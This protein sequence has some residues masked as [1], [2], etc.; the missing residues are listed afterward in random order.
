MVLQI[1]KICADKLPCYASNALTKRQRCTNSDVS[2]STAKVHDS[3]SSLSKP[4]EFLNEP[5]AR[6]KRKCVVDKNFENDFTK[7]PE[8]SNVNKKFQDQ[9]AKELSN[10][11]FVIKLE[12]NIHETGSSNS[13]TATR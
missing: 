3:E 8:R 11:S 4:Q 2:S 6:S 12:R 13:S 1:E 5:C 10:P 7:I 9:I